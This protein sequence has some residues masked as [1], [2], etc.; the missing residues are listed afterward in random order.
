MSRFSSFS[1]IPSNSAAVM[2]ATFG[3]GLRKICRMWEGE[4][5]GIACSSSVLM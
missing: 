3:R 2:S 5:G 4:G 1:V